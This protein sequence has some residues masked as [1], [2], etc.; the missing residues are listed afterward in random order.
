VLGEEMVRLCG[1]DAW[2]LRRRRRKRDRI[3]TLQ[4]K[5]EI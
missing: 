4:N 2:I 5:D 3:L 1:L